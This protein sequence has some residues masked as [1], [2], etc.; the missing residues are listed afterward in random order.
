MDKSKKRSGY[1]HHKRSDVDNSVQVDPI[2]RDRE[3]NKLIDQWIDGKISYEEM[4]CKHKQSSGDNFD[5]V[6]SRT[7]SG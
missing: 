3:F 1:L 6:F 2:E 4:K 5:I 7:K